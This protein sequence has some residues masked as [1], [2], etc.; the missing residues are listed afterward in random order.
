MS[1]GLNP[2]IGD[3]RNSS[4]GVG[5]WTAERLVERTYNNVGAIVMGT[6][7]CNTLYGMFGADI[8]SLTVIRKT[9]A[10][11]V[12]DMLKLDKL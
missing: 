8:G 11:T 5:F 12:P 7:A 1:F 4:Y 6:W 3:R 2:M 10:I 9:P